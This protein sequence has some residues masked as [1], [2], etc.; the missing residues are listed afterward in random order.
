M[1]WDQELSFEQYKI[2]GSQISR[3]ASQIM[4]V[5]R[6]IKGDYSNLIQNILF[7]FE[8]LVSRK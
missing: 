4:R 8:G 6:S 5:S 1:V 3:S 7:V 2:E